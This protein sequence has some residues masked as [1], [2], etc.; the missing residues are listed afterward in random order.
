MSPDA[1]EENTEFH[2]LLDGEQAAT[3]ERALDL[4]VSDEAH[5]PAIR[6]LAREVITRLHGHRS[7]AADAASFSTPLTAQQMKITHTAL[8]LRLNDSTRE[9]SAERAVL[10]AILEKLPDEHVMRAISLD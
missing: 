9:Q 8:G 2:L 10:H 6:A 4:L 1:S 3:A 5:E 7:E